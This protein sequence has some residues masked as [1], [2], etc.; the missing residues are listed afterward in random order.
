MERISI[1]VGGHTA[2]GLLAVTFLIII[3]LGALRWLF[4]PLPQQ[5]PEGPRKSGAATVRSFVTK[6]VRRRNR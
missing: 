2:I 1:L 5:D 3:V 6:A 4:Q